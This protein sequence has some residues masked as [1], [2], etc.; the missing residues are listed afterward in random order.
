MERIKKAPQFFVRNIEAENLL[1]MFLVS[2][3][4]SVLGIRFYLQITGYIQ[5]GGDTLHIAHMLW[6]GALMLASLVLMLGFLGNSAQR[7]A[8]VLGGVGFGAFI[9]ELG[10]FITRDNDY[11]F[12]PTIA[13]IYII[14]VLLYLAFRYIGQFQ[15]LSK[16]ESLLNALELTKEAVLHRMD[17]KEK[18]RL[19]RLLTN[20]DPAHPVRRALLGVMPELSA[21]TPKEN[22]Y[23][24]GRRL[25]H[26]LYLK[27]VQ[28]PW[29][30]ATVILIFIG[31]S[32]LAIA[33]AIL[34]VWRARGF[35]FAWDF[36]GI[37]L[38][39]LGELASSGFAG[40][41][42][43]AGIVQMRRSRLIAYHYFRYAVLISIFLTNVLL[44]FAEEF[45]ALLGLAGNIAL[46]GILNYMIHEEE[47]R[48]ATARK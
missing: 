21:V 2:A 1:E 18:A 38:L 45:G 7:L 43:L 3:V 22:L 29:F 12:Q 42:V 47:G 30:S 9:D 35:S 19:A 41:L 14:F 16:Q 34:V 25:V 28:A 39:E 6:G 48:G 33:Q 4:A 8:A 20:A 31:N 24:K 23:E 5:L 27:L 46:L 15:S 10:K 11:F 26:D 13:L 40:L 17:E 37:S 36:S 44:F 32:L